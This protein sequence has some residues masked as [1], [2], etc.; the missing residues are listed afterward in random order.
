MFIPQNLKWLHNKRIYCDGTF[1]VC[2]SLKDFNQIY[3]FSIK[4]QEDGRVAT[5]PVIYFLLKNKDKQ[6]YI[7]VFNHLKLIVEAHTEKPL[8]PVAFHVDLEQA[9][10]KAM[11]VVFPAVTIVLCSIH[12]LRGWHRNAITKCTHF[13][14]N[15]DQ[16]EFW[17]TLC[18]SIFMPLHND[19]IRNNFLLYFDEVESKLPD[20]LVPGFSE[21]KLYLVKFFFAK[22]AVFPLKYWDYNDMVVN[23]SENDTTTNSLETLNKKLKKK[24]GAGVMPLRRTLE[25]MR[26]FAKDEQNIFEFRIGQNRLNRRRKPTELR[27]KNITE[28]LELF[29]KMTLDE[30]V[31]G[32]VRFAHAFHLLNRTAN[33]ETLAFEFSPI[34]LL[35]Y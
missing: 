31:K 18:G 30:Q 22:D 16:R 6:S 34:E 28:Q 27:Y 7:T 10:V 17:T 3:L 19:Q 33:K 12:L 14:A 32:C 25:C 11:E 21:L 24:A 35:D 2:R 26:D 9:A 4:Q 1:S 20:P 15:T 29:H 13:F 5:F 23:Q 8:T